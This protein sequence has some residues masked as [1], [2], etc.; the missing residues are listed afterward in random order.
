[1]QKITYVPT[2]GAILG[3]QTDGGHRLPFITSPYNRVTRKDTGRHI[4]HKPPM[5]PDGL[6]A[7][8][9]TPLSLENWSTAPF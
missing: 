9:N 8:V 2:V 5:L 4:K 1:V 3:I 6:E 7:I